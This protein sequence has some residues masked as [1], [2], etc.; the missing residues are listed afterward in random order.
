MGRKGERELRDEKMQKSKKGEEEVARRKREGEEGEDGKRGNEIQTAE[1]YVPS[2][3]LAMVDHLLEV[4]NS[5]RRLALC[6][7]SSHKENK[8]I[9]F[10]K[11]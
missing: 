2:I 11:Q 10:S 1:G 4:C 9:C 5:L 3:I 8:D 6:F 7:E